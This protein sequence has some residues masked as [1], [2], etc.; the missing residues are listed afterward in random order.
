V[1]LAFGPAVAVAAP[2]ASPL[3][4]LPADAWDYAKARHL[5]ARAGFG[6][7]PED[8]KKLHGMGLRKAV[9]FLID[10]RT[11]PDVSFP[12]P[13][14][15]NDPDLAPGELA[16]LTREER[17]KVLQ[18]RRQIDPQFQRE[19]RDWWLRRMVE[20]P[21]PL[22][23]KMVLFW[24][25]H[26]ATEYRTVRSAEAM[27]RQ[28]RL[29]REHAAGN[30][31]T[32]LHGIVHDPA[33][34]RYLD[35]NR[36]VKGRPNENLAREIMEL[37]AMGADQGYTE[38]DIKEAA[39]ALTSYI[40]DPQTQKFRFAA[41]QHD[42]GE[43]T[44]FGKA[45]K[46]D[47]D[48]LV[49]LILAQPATA[50]FI[51]GKLFTYFVHESPD[52]RLLDELARVLRDNKYELAPLL[53][54]LFLSEEFYGPRAMSTQI[55]SP[56]QLVVGT[57]RTLKVKAEPAALAAAL[58]GMG[59]ELFE[60][61]NV[62][63]WE[64][65]RAWINTNTLFA[66]DNFAALLVAQGTGTAGAAPGR[67]ALGGRLAKDFD[68]TALFEGKK[69]DTP[70]AVVDHVA[71]ALL[72]VPLTEAKRKELIAFL[73][74]LPSSGRRVDQKQRVNARLAGLLVLVMSLPEY[75]MT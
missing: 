29:F 14:P 48:A 36:N 60:P 13:E 15:P 9:E 53:R 72:S 51:A 59:Q 64:G 1:L 39:R 3:K 67:P 37:F 45:G 18:K 19:V 35:N 32:L 68:P 52:D 17:Q 71:R 75:Q 74:D 23:E 70:A 66:R 25:G 55:K 2:E 43:K 49:D 46:Y 10:Y 28:N 33:M 27:L 40:L 6:G 5:L 56:V 21:R 50:R 58:R 73:G 34:L 20:S 63:G 54:I 22:E 38:K 24:H 11:Q 65:G 44:V 7:S 57:V 47:G 30:F 12:A 16:K 42:A 8:V 62:K 26:F 41:F 61:P 69:L 31:G 4:P